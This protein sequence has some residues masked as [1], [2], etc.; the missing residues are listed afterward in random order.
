MKFDDSE[1]LFIFIMGA[2]LGDS[3]SGASLVASASIQ[4]EQ[5]LCM[6]MERKTLIWENKGI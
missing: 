1:D 5:M 3:A 2:I 4:D 6:E